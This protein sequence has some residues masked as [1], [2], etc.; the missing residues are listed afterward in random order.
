M[1]LARTTGAGSPARAG[2]LVLLATL[3]AGCGLGETEASRPSTVEQ[4]RPPARAGAPATDRFATGRGSFAIARVRAG[5][6][7][8]LRARPGGRSVKRLSSRTEFGSRRFLAVARREGRWLGVVS[9]ERP[10]GRLGWVDGRSRALSAYRTEISLHADLSRRQ[11]ELRD[12]GRV[13]R[14][15]AVGIG[16]AGYA[17]PTGRFAVTDKLSGR[18]YGGTYGCCIVALSGHQIRLPPG[19][20]GG[21]RLALHGTRDQASIG[22]AAS[23]GCLRGGDGDLR[24]LLRRVPLGAPMFITI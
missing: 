21:D 24:A 9:A 20:P 15:F 19:W 7:I 14:R 5:R 17:T 11:V 23:T 1:P 4:A 8:A 12:G 13:V 2:A 16:R 6:S 22:S 10:N 3:M 18:P